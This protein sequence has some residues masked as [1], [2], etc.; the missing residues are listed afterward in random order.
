MEIERLR[1]AIASDLHDEVATNL[2]TIA[3]FSRIVQDGMGSG[4]TVG[5]ERA[6]LQERITSLAQESVGSI[7]DIIWALDP[8]KETL[9]DLLTRLEDVILPVCRAKGIRL[10]FQR[11]DA[12]NLPSANLSPKVRQHLW[13]L[14]K[15]GV[16]NAIK[17]S[18]CT[19][20]NVAIE[21]VSGRLHI[22]VADNGVG[23][24]AGGSTNGKGLG[25]MR[26]RAKQL[27]GTLE[28]A[29]S[30]GVGTVVKA[31]VGLND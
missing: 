6:Q 4:K 26:M 16:N 10:R 24:A 12:E 29:S 15:E 1:M 7:R 19:E 22:R 27:G 11:P 28:L 2:S 31:E 14:L 3:M 23:F 18:G 13:L 5:E 17:H 20:L 8:K 21:H 25:T 9:S 30:P